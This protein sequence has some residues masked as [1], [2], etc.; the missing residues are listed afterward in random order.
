MVL[1]LPH[2]AKQTNQLIHFRSIKTS[3]DMRSLLE[4]KPRVSQQQ[5]HQSGCR[6]VINDGCRGLCQFK[7]DIR[8]LVLHT[9][10]DDDDDD[11]DNDDY[12]DDYD[13]DD[14]DDNVVDDM[15]I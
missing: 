1:K 5:Q 11:D 8:D 12:D 14:Y 6:G 4:R 15:M 7:R 13:D 3:Y 2:P 10:H 9:R